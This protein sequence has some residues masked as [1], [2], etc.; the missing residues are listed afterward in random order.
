MNVQMDIIQV[1]RDAWS[2]AI[3]VMEFA[4]M[5]Q[6]EMVHVHVIQVIQHLRVQLITV[7]FVLLVMSWLAQIASNVL[8]LAKLVNSIQL[9]VLRTFHYFFFSSSFFPIYKSKEY[10]SFRCKS[11]YTLQTHNN[12]C[13]SNCGDGTYFNT[14]SCTGIVLLLS[15]IYN[16]HF[17]NLTVVPWNSLSRKLFNM[18]WRRW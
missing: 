2:V 16:I 3:V 5:D 8:R 6:M 13:T 11:G 9:I 12:T 7:L 10:T 1:M 4:R 18:L 17:I 15:F 14:S